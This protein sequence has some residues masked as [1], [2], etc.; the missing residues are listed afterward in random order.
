MP[1]HYN[2]ACPVAKA[3]E[4]IGDRWTLLL[5]ISFAVFPHVGEIVE[6]QAP[7]SYQLC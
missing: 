1:K 3:L 6:G 4:V 7:R 2:Q 5:V